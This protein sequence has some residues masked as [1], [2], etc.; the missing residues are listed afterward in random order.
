MAISEVMLIG[1]SAITSLIGVYIGM[2]I[3]KRSVSQ[4]YASQVVSNKDVIKEIQYNENRNSDKV[5]AKLD[6]IIG[7]LSRPVVVPKAK[8]IARSLKARKVIAE[9]KPKIE[10]EAQDSTEALILEELNRL[11]GQA[12]MKDI[13]VDVS[14]MTKYRKMLNLIE[15]GR[16]KKTGVFYHVITPEKVASDEGNQD[17]DVIHIPF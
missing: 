14:R 16:V 7:L 15:K 13:K 11:G 4:V 2:I 5:T 6:K 12:Q 9:I 1:C 10:R 17:N 3:Y 8:P